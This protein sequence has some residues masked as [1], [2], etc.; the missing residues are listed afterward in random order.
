[1]KHSHSGRK[2]VG[3]DKSAPTAWISLLV[4]VVLTITVVDSSLNI[5]LD[6]DTKAAAAEVAAA[7]QLE[8]I[9]V[10]KEQ[11]EAKRRELERQ[12]FLAELRKCESTMDDFKV[13]DGGASIGAYQW[14]KPTLEDIL[15]RKMSYAEYYAIA[16][17]YEKI[18]PITYHTY[19]ERKETWRWLNCRNKIMKQRA[20]QF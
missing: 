14:Q 9:A 6:L 13:G 10:E 20:W 7:A 15:G 3:Y 18:H 1:M 5:L 8:Q 17:D 2:L 4:L 12:W 19:F 16:T 11:A